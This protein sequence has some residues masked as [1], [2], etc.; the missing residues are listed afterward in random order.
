MAVFYRPQQWMLVILRSQGNKVCSAPSVAN[1]CHSDS[2]WGPWCGLVY[3]LGWNRACE[4]LLLSSSS[5]GHQVSL[6][7]REVSTL[8]FSGWAPP[9]PAA[10]IGNGPVGEMLDT[11]IPWRFAASLCFP[12]T[13]PPFLCLTNRC[14]I[15]LS[16]ESFHKKTTL[17]C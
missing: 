6:C 17:Y 15:S 12:A 4:Q 11:Q 14:L 1:C 7:S 13:L 2:V 5:Q 16:E 8:L 3:S 10:Q 9:G